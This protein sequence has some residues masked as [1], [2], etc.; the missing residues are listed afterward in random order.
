MQLNP[1]QGLVSV[2][3]LPTSGE[4][5]PSPAAYTA[6][7][8]MAAAILAR[9]AAGEPEIPITTFHLFHAGM[10]HRTILVP[11]GREVVGAMLRR[12]TTLV[13]CG[14]AA[15]L[16]AEPIRVKGY[17][18]LAGLEGRQTG[19]VTYE[20]TWFTMIVPTSH[21]TVE[22]IDAEMVEAGQPLFAHKF[23]NVVVNT[24]VT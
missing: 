23:H 22:A 14:D 6:A 15:I 20:D 9:Q 11:K 24:G 19:L 4:L 7:H 5:A 13:V 10:Y 8:R 12:A 16:A 21:T 18:V 3:G 2:P 17:A 1:Y